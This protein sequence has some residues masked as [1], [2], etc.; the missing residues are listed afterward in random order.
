MCVKIV[1][2]TAKKTGCSLY[3]LRLTDSDLIG[4]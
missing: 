1:K 2:H 4:L 3:S